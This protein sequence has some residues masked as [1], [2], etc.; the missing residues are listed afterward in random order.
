MIPAVW[1]TYTDAEWEEIKAVVQQA[2]GLDADRIE[3]LR[4]SL[5]AAAGV[6]I[7]RSS[8]ES[9]TPGH[10]ARIKRLTALLDRAEALRADL[11]VA[12][13][14]SFTI[15]DAGTVYLLLQAG[16]KTSDDLDAIRCAV[17]RVIDILEASIAT[18]RPQP[19]A[20]TAK[21][22]RDK[23]WSEVLAIWTD[24]IGGAET[25]RAAAEFLVATSKPVFRKL[26]DDDTRKTTASMPQHCASVVEWLRLRAKAKAGGEAPVLLE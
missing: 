5:E 18:Q 20:N 26:L 25:G 1:F 16:D 22:V 14:P 15:G 13:A 9:R 7:P 11:L 6:H 21:A 17:A 24:I 8:V 4:D 19:T 23:F 2:L 12:L 10:K 3:S